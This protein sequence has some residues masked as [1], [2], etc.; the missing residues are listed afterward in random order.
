MSKLT[1]TQAATSVNISRSHLY[2]KYISQGLISVE[3]HDGKKF[4]DTSE[5]IRVFG[6]ITKDDIKTHS[7]TITNTPEHTDKDKII[8]ILERELAETKQQAQER[9]I[10]LKQQID[11]LRHQQNNLLDNKIAQKRKKFL[12]IF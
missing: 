10:W 9:E 7:E 8:L 5:L 11:E 6:N 1:I 4:I 2:K 12:G 3:V